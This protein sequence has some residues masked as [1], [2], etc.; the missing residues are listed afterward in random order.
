[1]WSSVCINSILLHSRVFA[2]N[3]MVPFKSNVFH[4]SAFYLEIY[5][6][7]TFDKNKWIEKIPFTI[8]YEFQF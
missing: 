6:V 5:L 7:N 4:R 3:F 8:I 2:R 1:M